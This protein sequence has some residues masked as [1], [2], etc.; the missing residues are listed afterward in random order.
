MDA[1]S[2]GDESA[3]LWRR[4]WCAPARPV[5]LGFCRLIF[6]GWLAAFYFSVDFSWAAGAPASLWKPVWL[7]QVLHLGVLPENTLDAM[8][9]LFR[10]ALVMSC[11]GLLTRG[12]TAAAFIAGIYLLGLGHNFGKTGHGDAALVWT[13]GI[14]ALSRCGDAWSIDRLIRV[15]RRRG[16]GG[17]GVAWPGRGPI[18]RP[19]ISAEYTWP[20][21]A[22]WLVLSCVFFGAG[23]SKLAKSGMD[24]VFSDNF[25]NLLIQHHYIYHPMTRLGLWI[26]DHPALCMML[27]AGTILIELAFPLVLISRIARTVLAPAMFLIQIGIGIMLSV[28]FTQF[29]VCYLFFVPWD[30]LGAAIARTLRRLAPGR[31]VVFYDGQCGL[32]QASVRMLQSLDWLGKFDYRDAAND[33]TAISARFPALDRE[34]CL[35][36]MHAIDPAGRIRAGFDAYRRFAR[37]LPVMWPLVPLAH[38]PGAATIGRRVYRWIADHRVRACA[39]DGSHVT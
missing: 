2:V 26:A 9:I 32:C 31:H 29:I 13:M 25:S 33:W 17:G 16:G 37:A 38:L 24:W 14:L 34:A 7:F 4:V 15:A 3:S 10:I 28:W 12:A 39:L 19:V 23:V 18:Q 11:I 1:T 8:Q 36:D 21:R 30:R 27:A 22:V 6:F 35:R 20:I 5:N